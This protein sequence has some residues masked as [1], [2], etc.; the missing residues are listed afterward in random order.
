[1]PSLY[2]V[3][4]RARRQSFA[5]ALG[6]GLR[7][8]FPAQSSWRPQASP[9]IGRC[10]RNP[11]YL[12]DCRM[13]SALTSA[14]ELILTSISS[15]SETSGVS[16]ISLLFF[17]LVTVEI[18]DVCEMG[19]VA[20]SSSSNLVRVWDPP[21]VNDVASPT[22]AGARRTPSGL[23]EVPCGLLVSTS[24]PSFPAS[25]GVGVHPL[26]CQSTLERP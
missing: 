6:E 1:M 4:I 10:L 14:A 3:G 15:S 7:S 26:A 16:D 19:G 22:M 11:Y 23:F 13:T 2:T 17:P 18:S 25:P 20:D 12:G 9:R 8:P 5:I 21:A 24:I